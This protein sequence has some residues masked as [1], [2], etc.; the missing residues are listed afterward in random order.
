[1]PVSSL[2]AAVFSINTMLQ[3]G[4]LPGSSCAVPSLVHPQGGHTYCFLVC[5]G[6]RNAIAATVSEPATTNSLRFITLSSRSFGARLGAWRES[7]TTF[8]L[9]RGC[10]QRIV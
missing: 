6:V 9:D 5:A 3:A 4:Q 8:L 10:L 2:M 7:L 1:M